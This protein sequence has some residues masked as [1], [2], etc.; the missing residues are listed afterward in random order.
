M[1]GV[2][3]QKSTFEHS[4]S[5][6]TLAIFNKYPNPFAT[7]VLQSDVL[8]RSVVT[9]PNGNHQLHTVR[10]HLK[11]GMVPKW[12]AAL[13]KSA[14]YAF[15]LED[16]VVDAETKTMTTRTRNLDHRRFL[17]VEEISVVREHPEVKDWY[18]FFVSTEMTTEARIVSN[19]GW[20]LTQKLEM[21]GLQ[22]FTNNMTN[23][24]QGLLH[25]LA[26]LR[27][28]MGNKPAVSSA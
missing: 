13:F 15:I 27:N 12:G 10:L 19:I 16:T 4:W 11:S 20:G 3:Q 9:L 28:R 21:F 2:F 6:L 7:H 1:V 25:V 14:P 5:A 22:R 18:P 26:T 24:R 17:Y 23:S 8:S